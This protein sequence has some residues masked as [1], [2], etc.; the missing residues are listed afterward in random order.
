MGRAV[1]FLRAVG[2]NEGIRDAMGS[3]G[4]V[5][6]D[7]DEGWRLLRA[8]CEVPRVAAS[9]RNASVDEALRKLD[10]FAK[11]L[12]VRVRAALRR[13]SPDEIAFLLNGLPAKRGTS[14]AS[15]AVFLDRCDALSKKDRAALAALGKH[16]IGA[17]AREEAR[18][19]IS[20]ATSLEPTRRA[21]VAVSG[22]PLGELYAWT[23]DWSDVARTVIV[24]RDWLIR[25]GIGRR[26]KASTTA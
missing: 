26:K 20:V 13:V 17:G 11:V 8:A 25:L 3:A 4:F 19:W 16:G 15:V 9:K 5:K 12:A 6:E 1:V 24:R 10:D 14:V 21:P 7:A 18:R 23:K 22:D 2:T